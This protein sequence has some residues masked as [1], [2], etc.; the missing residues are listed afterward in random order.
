MTLTRRLEPL[1]VF[2]W[3]VAAASIT[4][5]W[6][7]MPN[8]WAEAGLIILFGIIIISTL[9]QQVELPVLSTIF[10]ALTVVHYY[11][12]GYP[13]FPLFGALITVLIV[14]ALGL[15]GEKLNTETNGD[16]SH[17]VVGSWLV[18]GLITAEA[19]NVFSYWPVSFFNRSLLTGTAFY[20]FWQLI[21]I[22]KTGERRRYFTHFAFVTLTVIVILGIIIW[23]NF[24][25]LINF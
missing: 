10:L 3:L 21:I 8:H 12:I 5:L 16:D 24:P 6:R 22:Q 4:I 23:V 15:A 11:Q 25:H 7:F 9:N 13:N 18:L 2:F 14:P 19:V 20:T 1:A 17:L